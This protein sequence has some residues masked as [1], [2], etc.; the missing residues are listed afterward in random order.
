[1]FDDL[2]TGEY[3][4]T[5][6]EMPEG[7]PAMVRCYIPKEEDHFRELEKLE[8]GVVLHSFLDHE[9]SIDTVAR[10]AARTGLVKAEEVTVGVLPRGKYL[11]M[12]PN[13]INREA[14]IKATPFD[15]WDFGYEFQ[16]WSAHD[17]A[18]IVIPSFKILVHLCGLPIYLWKEAHAI[19][20][21]SS[22]GTYLGALA[23]SEVGK[24]DYWAAVVAT[25]DLQHVPHAASIRIGGI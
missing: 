20:A 4:T 18:S 21:V 11:I 19:S 24:L 12:L 13:G 15:L 10:Y 17:E 23:R 25:E 14:F 2:L 22:F 1:M 9:L 3:P 7:R 8:Q 5:P 16:P 6:P